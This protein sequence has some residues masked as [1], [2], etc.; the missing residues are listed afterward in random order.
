MK[1]NQKES[2]KSFWKKFGL[3]LGGISLVAL[4]AVAEK[5]FGIVDRTISGVTKAYGVTKTTVVNLI[6]KKPQVSNVDVDTTPRQSNQ[7]NYSQNRK[8]NN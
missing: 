6:A 5:K 7:G 8:Y 4:G 1:N 2:S 3:V